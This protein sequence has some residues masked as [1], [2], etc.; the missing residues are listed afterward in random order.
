MIYGIGIDSVHIER[1]HK[2]I[3]QYG[4][5]FA[6]K[7]LSQEEW[8]QYKQEKRPACFLAKHFA[9]KEAMAKALGTGFRN[10]LSLKHII[11][12]HNEL[13]KPEIKCHGKAND[14]LLSQNINSSYLSITD[15]KDYALACV[16]L[17]KS[18]A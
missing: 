18:S 9:A 17:E 11:I 4:D 13:G 1:M 15:E 7:I 12:T 5:R 14:L 2:N 8:G 6:E 16:V 3:H 10:G